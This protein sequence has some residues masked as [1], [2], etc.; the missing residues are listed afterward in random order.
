MKKRLYL[1]V[2]VMLSFT[3]NVHALSYNSSE[4]KNRKECEKF[5]LA[6]ANSDGSIT[7]VSCFNDYAMAKDK[8]N[9]DED[10]TLIILERDNDI[11]K[12]IDAKYALLYLDKGDK[13]TYLY[14]SNSCKT[15]L[16]Y[17]DN[18]SGYGAT[19]AAFIEMN[20]NNHSVKAKIAGAVGWLKKGT[21]EIIPAP[22]VKSWSYY[23]VT[24]NGLYHYYSKNIENTG[25]SQSNRLIDDKPSF[26]ENGNYRSY[27]GIYFYSDIYTMID[28]Y[29]E[30][31]HDLAVNK[32]NPY[33]NY[34]QYLPHRSK[35]NYDIEDFDS[36][37]RNVLNFKG[38]LYGKFLTNNNSVMYGTSEYY[39]NAEKLYGA[40]ALSI[41]SLARHESANGRSYI[42][43]NKNNLFGHN[44]VDGAA[45]SSATGYL[46]ARSSIYTHGYGYINYGYAKV[47]DWRY[48]GSHFGN[49][50]TGMNVQYA[51]D[52]YWGE[53]AAS[54]YYSF[55]KEN[56]LLDKDYYQLII[57]EYTNVN[58]RVAPKTSSKSAYT[59]KKVGLPFIVVDEVHGETVA[60][61]DI[62]YKIQSDSN[63]TDTGSLI[64]TSKND[65]AKYNWTGYLYVHSSFFK[66]IN[67]G[68]KTNDKYNS[69]AS[70][71]KDI[72]EYEITTYANTS[73]YIPEVGIVEND[74][75]FYYTMNLTNKKGTI[76]KNSYVV[77]LEKAVTDNDLNYL[78]ITDYSTNQKAWIN[79][80]DVR[81]IKK[82]L[83]SFRS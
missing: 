58:V 38:S 33:Y 72:N 49:K 27:D 55:D 46:D 77:I 7:K 3:I 74:I 30:N 31:K 13:L 63:I 81:L 37:I 9:T 51:S 43:Y 79:G 17:M 16:T 26:M 11:T 47:S 15:E 12:V 23:K 82:D 28:D 21:Y 5:E 6:K 1:I 39:L 68:K 66:K 36:Y 14:T 70:I 25:Y 22:W 73:K 45:Y 57:S 19:D 64:S 59:I 32:D 18:Y 44:A 48:N 4:L 34:Y 71:N 76:K 78:V 42:S 62:W 83:V 20:Y 8:M 52:V 53:K 67:E 40:N 10:K 69:P 41:F 2:F 80:K 35:T 60:G 65:W 61:S 24:D 54:Y 75:D 56:G 29:R 50:N